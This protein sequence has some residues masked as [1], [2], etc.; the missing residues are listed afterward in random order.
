MICVSTNRVQCG[1]DNS[2]VYRTFSLSNYTNVQKKVY[3][4]KSSLFFLYNFKNR[5]GMVRKYVVRIQPNVV[6][7]KK[8][9]E[10]NIFMKNVHC[11]K[12]TSGPISN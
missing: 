1:E 6:G 7:D 4:V 2:E 3:Q 10:V 8:R 12:K 9:G 11:V 5:Y